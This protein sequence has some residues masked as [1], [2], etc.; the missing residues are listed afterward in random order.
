M[1][2]I[3]ITGPTGAGKTTVLNEL[4]DMGFET[5]DCDALYYEVLRRD[6]NL[7][8]GL[9][10]TFGDVFLPDGELDRPALGR[11]VFGDSA[12]LD[13]LNAL[14][15]PAMEKAVQE[16][17]INCSGK[18]LAIDAINLLQSGLADMCGLTVAVISDP[19]VR[20]RRIMARDGISEERAKARVAAQMPDAWFRE[21]CGLSVENPDAPS[22]VFRS[23]LE[24]LFQS[25]DFFKNMKG[26]ILSMDAKELKETLL[27]K[28]KNGYNGLTDSDREAMIAYCQAYKAF[29]DNGKTER[30]CVSEG[31]R[32]AEA[33][34]FKAY[35]RGMELHPGDKVYLNNR[36]KMLLLA[37]I[38]KENLSKGA[39]ITAAHIDSPR[40]DLKPSPL[41]EDNE[42]AYLK[43]H[44][45]GGIRKYQW[46]TLPLELHGVVAMKDGTVKNVVIGAGDEPKLVISDLLPHLAKEQSK[47]SL[48]EGIAGEQLNLLIGSEPLKDGGDEKDLVKLNAMRLL[49]EKYGFTEGDF[50]S[51]ELEAVPAANATDIG[52]DG[53]LI[54]AYGHDDRVCGYAALKALLD[55]TETPNKT[56]VCVLADK[57]EIGSVGVSGMQTHAFDTFMEDLCA[58]QNVP[59]RVCLENSFCLSTDVTAAYDPNFSEVFEKNNSSYINY[60]VGLCK[61]T[62]SRGKSGASDASAELVAYAR[63]ILDENHI[64]WQMAE[65]GKVDV[66]GGG[67]VAGY[68]ANRNISTLDAGVPVLAMHAPFEIVSKL[69]CY[70]TYR[71]MQAVYMN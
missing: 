62:G 71:A 14:V 4:A 6:E 29:L 1:K 48:D 60:G 44:Y 56:S 63:R 10:E 53:S 67:T 32:Q 5:V 20:V 54:G 41:F 37:V 40:L 34:G 39:Q 64:L 28:K 8:R 68:M 21:R 31:I 9:R 13:K 16:K 19:A 50:I 46:V 30:E 65:L 38:G 57:E 70:M 26:A 35:Q 22:E 7:R 69:D 45:Y 61:Y 33:K 49:Y 24:T 52:L 58:S 11:R 17:I 47:K 2:I 51:A 43:T 55:L 3:G 27:T 59:V 23:K 25:T 18:G 12:E 66:G 36:G 42:L 15:F